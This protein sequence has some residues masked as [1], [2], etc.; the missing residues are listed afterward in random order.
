MTTETKLQKTLELVTDVQSLAV[1]LLTRVEALENE[2]KE[3][4]TRLQDLHGEHNSHM[5]LNHGKI[6]ERLD[7]LEK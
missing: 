7:N 2:N 6:E 4:R 1:K 3:L 5:T